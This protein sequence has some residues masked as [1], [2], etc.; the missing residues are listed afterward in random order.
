ML[1][2]F[3]NGAYA[4]P[5][6]V[7][8]WSAA[9]WNNC[10]GTFTW[11]SG[12][13]HVGEYKDGKRNGQGTYTFGPNSEWAGDKY[14]G[15][16]KD[17]KR[18][19]QGTYTFAN[20]NKYV[21]EYKDGKKSGQGTFTWANGDN[22]I[23]EYKD[24][25]RNGQGTLTYGPNSEWAGD[26]YVGEYTY[27]KRTGQGTYTFSNGTIKEGIWKDDK[28]QYAKKGPSGNTQYSLLKNTFKKYVLSD[29]KQIQSALKTLRLY[30]GSIDGIWGPN[31][32]RAVL[33]YA[34]NKGINTK[35][36]YNVYRSI[37]N[38]QTASGSS[39]DLAVKLD[40]QI[41][42]MATFGSPKKWETGHF[43]NYVTEAKKRGLSCGVGT[44]TALGAS[45]LPKCVGSWSNN[46]TNCQGTYTFPSGEKY[47]GEFKDDK[48]HGQ[49]TYTYANGNKYVGE[50]KDDKMYGQGT[51]T[52][53][54]GEKWVGEWENDNLNGYAIT[55]NADGSIN[56]EGIFKDDVFQ[57]AQEGPADNTQ[58]AT[59]IQKTCSND[60]TACTVFQ[61]CSNA[62]VFSDGELNWST[63]S[64]G[65][66]YVQEAKKNGVSCNVKEQKPKPDLNKTYK[67]A[68]GTG[69]YV[70]NTG[71]LITNDHVVDGCKD[72]KV[73]SNGADIS[74]VLLATD[75]KNDLALLKANHT[76]SIYF[77]ISDQ[78]PEE[79]QDVIV[80]G[81]P[82][83]D[84]ISSAIKF[85]QG[86][87]S[88]LAG[89][90][91]DYSQFQIDAAL[92]PGNSGGPIVDI[93]GNILGVAVA[94]LDFKKIM[95]D[96]GVVAENT[97][98]GIKAS[99]VRNLMVG[100]SIEVKSPKSE[101]MT[102]SELVKSIKA[103]TVHLTCWMTM[104]Q[105]DE[106]IKAEDSK[107]LFNKF[108]K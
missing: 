6:C 2:A 103:G 89:I 27:G 31:T 91:N 32:Q 47:V 66:K 69:F 48:R 12:D 1:F 100:N 75:P 56:Q 22:Y 62:L 88:S 53:A 107:V 46:W 64:D 5:K 72:I 85:T 96:Y 105:I 73:Q 15:E 9:T 82:F 51:F 74:T 44:Q 11:A 4:L 87:V 86:I 79:V 14:V 78:D 68:S 34:S 18:N 99:A 23:G 33:S 43:S 58:T 45:T 20:G 21:G 76:P 54:S 36:P 25:K 29:R 42:K 10:F 95:D 67:V 102:T 55:Y 39:N 84:A 80:A 57:Y 7:G 81:Y 97:N 94:K 104:A 37:L 65:L 16:Y 106:M 52:F 19:G 59:N 28:F 17:D 49:G 93:Y 63:S 70:S 77:S 83:G 3:T 92:Q 26:K 108:S 30:F 90:G 40:S 98:F 41:C 35:D 60:P 61:L 8:S 38:T 13:K 101:T 71:H 50:Y 24:G